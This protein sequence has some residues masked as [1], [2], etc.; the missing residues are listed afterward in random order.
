M[1][2]PRG[3]KPYAITLQRDLRSPFI[4][5]PKIPE[6]K[7]KEKEETKAEKQEEKDQDNS[8]QTEEENK[9]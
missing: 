8:S 9:K 6:E 3:V 7:E 2:F 4:A 5:E 1:S